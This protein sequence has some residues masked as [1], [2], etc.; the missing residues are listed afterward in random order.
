MSSRRRRRYAVQKLTHREGVLEGAIEVTDTAVIFYPSNPDLKPMQWEYSELLRYRY[1][2]KVFKFDAAG[3]S[4]ASGAHTFESKSAAK[5]FSLVDR[6]VA[7]RIGQLK[8]SKQV[9]DAYSLTLPRQTDP[10]RE[11]LKK[12]RPVTFIISSPDDEPRRQ[13]VARKHDSVLWSS[14]SDEAFEEKTIR[15]PARD[16]QP[17]ARPAMPVLSWQPS[18]VLMKETSP[19]GEKSPTDGDS[20]LSSLGTMS[21]AK[22]DFEGLSV[23][24]IST[25]LKQIHKCFYFLIANVCGS[26]ALLLE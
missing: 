9:K 13:P 5:I 17:K 18:T 3:I 14:S 4:A 11:A 1:D 19:F 6:N 24:A 8:T 7:K 20:G 21:Y 26:V 2:E 22:I 10:P 15:P 16:Y 23:S 12:P 25:K